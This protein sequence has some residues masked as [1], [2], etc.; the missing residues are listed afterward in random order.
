MTPTYEL[1]TPFIVNANSHLSLFDI[2]I[3]VRLYQPIIGHQATALYLTL[4][5]DYLGETRV[6]TK[7]EFTL[8]RLVNQMQFPLNELNIARQALEAYRLIDTYFN[9]AKNSLRF[10]LLNPLSVENFFKN[11]VLVHSLSLRLGRDELQRTKSYFMAPGFVASDEVKVNATLQNFEFADASLTNEAQPAW[12]G[13]VTSAPSGSLKRTELLRIFKDYQLSERLLTSEIFAKLSALATI[14]RFSTTDLMMLVNR[15]IKGEGIERFIDADALDNAA[16]SLSRTA[17]K[18]VTPTK[19]TAPQTSSKLTPLQHLQQRNEGRP[20]LRVDVN[21]IVNTQQQT[22]LN[23]EVMNEVIDYVLE[24]Q[25][26]NLPSAYFQKVATH[27]M[28]QKA[29]DAEVARVLLS[30]FGSRK[31]NEPTVSTDMT[32]N[33]NPLPS[34]EVP[35]DEEIARLMNERNERLK[36]RQG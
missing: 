9:E 5:S 4:W 24:K 20:P 8:Q 34:T 12:M 17:T 14:Y 1:K 25:S 31:G 32:M 10:V 7:I 36:R 33:V 15:S 35:S 3:L 13:T 19:T 6:D 28:R 11:D 21:L 18:K 27:L 23:D 22:G 16:I 26:G 2:K 30:S 29:S